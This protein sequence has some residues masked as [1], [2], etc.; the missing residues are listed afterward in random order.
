VRHTET[1]HEVD[2][3]LTLEG[4]NLLHSRNVALDT[5]PTRR[6]KAGRAR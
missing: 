5:A 1:V 4:L 2:E 3:H 6:A